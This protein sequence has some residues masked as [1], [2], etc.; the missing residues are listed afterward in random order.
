MNDNADKMM[1]LFNELNNTTEE[2]SRD[3][4]VR[5][6]F[7]YP[8]GKSK[9][10][11]EIIP[12]LPQTS[13]YVEPFGGSGSVLLAR[14]PSGL[15]VLND[16]YM[17]V[18]AFY[19]CI[20]NED[21]MNRLCDLIDI[22]IHSREEWVWCKET[23]ENVNDDVERAARWYYMLRYSFG[24]LCRNFGR[25]T[26]PRGR[27]AGKIR[28]N[29]PDFPAIH[30]RL[31]HVQI[32]NQ[33]WRQC[34]DDYDDHDTVFYIDPPY[35]DTDSGIYKSKMYQKDHNELIDMVFS[36]KGFCAVSGY[37]NPFYDNRPWDDRHE[38][39]AFVSMKSMAYTDQNKKGH[40]EGVEERGTS[41]EVLWIKEAK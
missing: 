13:R 9:S 36:C 15:E 37:D 3:E 32:E 17:G 29:V 33:D 28:N 25:S 34:I 23:W 4:I 21:K 1:N 26:S 22:S 18:V 31:K 10:I 40:L 30:Q 5:S 38:W 20:K 35:I 41:K 7:N 12:Y 14:N 6:P 27:I 11:H 24:G 8:G 19:R 2:K 39:D 16:R